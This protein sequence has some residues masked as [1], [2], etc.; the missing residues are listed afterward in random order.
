MIIQFYLYR[1]LLHWVQCL[2]LQWEQLVPWLR[3][4]CY[5]L[6]P[7]KQ[8]YARYFNLFPQFIMPCDK[9]LR[10]DNIRAREY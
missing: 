2:D 7:S 4:H 10:I 3:F 8:T 9:N 6:V 5:S 1:A